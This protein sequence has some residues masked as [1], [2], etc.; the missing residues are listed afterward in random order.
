MIKTVPV[1]N[2]IKKL[3]LSDTYKRNTAYVVQNLNS[4]NFADNKRD[5]SETKFI[6]NVTVLQGKVADQV[7]HFAGHKGKKPYKKRKR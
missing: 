1:I 6:G 4:T 2:T 3:T 7:Q 5:R